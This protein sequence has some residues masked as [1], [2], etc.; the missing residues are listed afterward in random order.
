MSGA[1][2]PSG[3]LIRGSKKCILKE[4]KIMKDPLAPDHEFM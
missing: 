4:G 2:F 3:A 1:L